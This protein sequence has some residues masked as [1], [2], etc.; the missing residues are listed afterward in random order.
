M[1]R[2][3]SSVLGATV[4]SVAATLAVRPAAAQ[5]NSLYAE[6]QRPAAV[7]NSLAGGQQQQPPG[8]PAC[9]SRPGLTLADTSWTYQTLVDHKTY[10]INDIV[11]VTVSVKSQMTSTGTVDRKKTGYS[12]WKLT[13]WIKIFPGG[14]LGENGGT[15]GQPNYGT[16]EVRGDL[17]SKLQASGNLQTKDMMSFVISCHV[18]DKRPNGNLVLEGTWSVSDNEEKW[19]YSLAGEC[20]ADD[21]KDGNTII[22]DNIALL[23][24]GRQEA[25]SVR[26]SYRRGW[27]LQWLDKWQP[28]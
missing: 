12:D 25:G 7:N 28:F 11:K 2:N 9:G 15:T 1:Q 13:D 27:A 17:D 10:E 22:S 3:L 20:R 5:N 18:V 4:L 8:A 16:P 26:D 19:E 21:I 6:E 14:N 24:I 23:R